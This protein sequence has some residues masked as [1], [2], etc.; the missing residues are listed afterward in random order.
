MYRPTK[1]FGGNDPKE[2]K[3]KADNAARQECN[4]T[5]DMALLSGNSEE[6][7]LEV[8]QTEIHKKV[9]QAVYQTGWLSHLF[10]FIVGK[11]WDFLQKLICRR[12]MLPKPTLDI[13]MAGF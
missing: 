9:R 11:A 7:I 2:E 8:K 3:I 5:A 4:R 10:W 1:K 13:D 6:E 12:E